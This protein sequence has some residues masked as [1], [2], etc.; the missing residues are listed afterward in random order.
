MAVKSMP[1]PGQRVVVTFTMSGEQKGVCTQ[2]LSTQW[3]LQTDSGRELVVHKN[4][5][6]YKL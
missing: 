2:H 6:W 3:V 5:R 4:D 1:A